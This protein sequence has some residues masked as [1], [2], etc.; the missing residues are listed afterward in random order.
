ME[1]QPVTYSYVITEL[2]KT[3][4]FNGRDPMLYIGHSFRIGAASIV[5]KLR[6]KGK[7]EFKRY[8][9]IYPIRWVQNTLPQ[10]G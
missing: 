4:T 8:Q 5:A 6:K 7:M 3:V 1:G 10:L 9:K 2:H